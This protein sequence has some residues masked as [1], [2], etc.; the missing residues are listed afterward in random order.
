MRPVP[1]NMKF[2]EYEIIRPFIRYEIVRRHASDGIVRPLYL[3][4]FWTRL[5]AMRIAQALMMA[6]RQGLWL[7]P[8]QAIKGRHDVVAQGAR[9]SL[10]F[11]DD[12]GGLPPVRPPD[13]PGPKDQFTQ[14]AVR[15][16]IIKP[17]G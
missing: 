6:Q 10:N 9:R 14:A 2:G 1:E 17:K 5:R 15:D 16:P 13:D 3:G 12:Q 8:V 4:R 11:S 7:G